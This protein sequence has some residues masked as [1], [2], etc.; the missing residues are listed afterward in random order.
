VTRHHLQRHTARLV[1]APAEFQFLCGRCWRDGRDRQVY[2]DHRERERVGRALPVV[3][4]CRFKCRSCPADYV[5]DYGTV[6]ARV[7]RALASGRIQLI[8]G[9]D[10]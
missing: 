3:F 4:T 1:G 9:E 8:L 6:K 7:Q 2:I 10:L 5:A